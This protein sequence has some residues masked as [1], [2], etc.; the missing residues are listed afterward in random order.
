MFFENLMF[1]RKNESIKYMSQG[2]IMIYIGH[3]ENGCCK[4]DKMKCVRIKKRMSEISIVLASNSPRRKQILSWAGIS[5]T[6]RPA[7]INETP[8]P[9]ETPEEYVQRLAASK[10]R[11]VS[12]SAGF[13]DL[14]LA[15]DTTVADAKEI[16]GKPANNEEAR[17]MLEKLRG[18]VHFVHTAVAVYAPA[19]GRMEEELCTTRV[20]MRR[21]TDEEIDLYIKTGD[22]T[23]KAGAYGIQNVEFHPVDQLKGCFA[24]VMGLPLC[25]VERIL[26]RMGYGERTNVPYICQ[27][28]LAYN[29]PIFQRVLKGEDIG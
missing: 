29:C 16:L 4:S 5:F 20:R 22:P 17:L 15:A 24:S 21:Y 12:G 27:D 13:K 19:F 8:L 11:K 23:D 18:R 9:N 10:A 3:Q 6:V 7:D 14:I 26:R 25:H 2:K 1:L 28:Q